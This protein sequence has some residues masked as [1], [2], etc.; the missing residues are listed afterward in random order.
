M[1]VTP[2]SISML[3]AGS[4]IADLDVT[5]VREDGKHFYAA[6]LQC[7]DD[8]KLRKRMMIEEFQPILQVVS[9]TWHGCYGRFPNIQFV[10]TDGSEEMT[11]RVSYRR[12]EFAVLFFSKKGPFNRGS[13]NVG[14]KIKLLD[15]TTELRKEKGGCM[16]PIIRIEKFRS[17]PR[18]AVSKHR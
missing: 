15:Y 17:E 1:I 14:R 3:I 18:K 16:G 4:K 13:L 11:M 9:R 6:L 8:D 5:A 10:V 2:G 7:E 12:T